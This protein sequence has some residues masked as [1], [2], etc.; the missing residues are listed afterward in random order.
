MRDQQLDEE[1]MALDQPLG[2]LCEQLDFRLLRLGELI[3][4][5]LQNR[6][7][8]GMAPVSAVLRL[9]LSGATCR[10]SPR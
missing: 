4:K 8:E 5:P 6:L 3:P 2:N 1:L 7:A 10:R 9:V